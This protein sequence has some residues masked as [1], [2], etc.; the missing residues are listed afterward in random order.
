MLVDF[1]DAT[2][3]VHKAVYKNELRGWNIDFFVACRY[4]NIYFSFVQFMWPI[5]NIGEGS[6]TIKEK[7]IET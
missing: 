7:W 5:E 3:N 1:S 4:K 6:K 2:N